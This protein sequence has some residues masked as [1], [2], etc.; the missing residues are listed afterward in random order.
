MNDTHKKGKIVLWFCNILLIMVAVVASMVY[1]SHIRTTQKKVKKTDFITTV[2][3]MKQLSQNY[4]DGEK[5]YLNN[6]A[7]YITKHDMTLSESLD[8]LRQINTNKDRFA[9]IVDMDTFQ[10][11]SSYYPSGK[12]EISTY[13]YYKQKKHLTEYE[14]SFVTMMQKMFEG[15]EA[16]FSV[17]GKITIPETLES[18]VGLGAKVSIKTSYGKKDYLLVR[19]VPT[20]AL[21]RN[22]VFPV[23]YSSAEVGII[24]RAGD[25]VIQSE[26]MKS[27]S[28]LEYIRAYNFSN[29]YNKIRELQTQ[30]K[31]TDYGT[32]TY[33]NF[34]GKDCLW[35]YSSFGK[36]SDLNILGCVNLEQLQTSDNAW[37]IV[38]LICVTLVI[39]S[40]IDGSYFYFM[41]RKL[42]ETARLANQASEAKTQFLS[43]MSHDIRTPMNGVLGMMSIA[44]KNINN[45]EYVMECLDKSMNAGKQLL[46]LINDVLDISKI[47]SGKLILSKEK[48]NLNEMI[49]GLVDMLSTQMQEKNLAFSCDLDGLAHPDVCADKMRLNQVF[50]N[51]L[52]NAVKYTNDG[53]SIWLTLKEEAFSEEEETTSIVF[54]VKDTGIGM[55]EEFQ[56]NMYTSFSRA[57]STQVNETQGTGLGL[58][59]VKQM[60]NLM[61]GSI[62]CTSQV[63]V[64]STFEVRLTLPILK[65]IEDV[66]LSNANEK[67]EV[68]DL[69]LLIAEDNELN[70]EIIEIM[71]SEYGVK[72]DRVKNGLLCLKRIQKVEAGTYDAILMDIQMPIMNGM[73][74][75]KNIRALDDDRKNKIPIIA[76]TADAFAEDVQAC[77][78]CGMNGHIAKPIDSSKL[79]EYL[80]KIKKNNF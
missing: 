79:L 29:D 59:I 28:F 39:L 31:Y 53:G 72:V 23:E 40:L 36:D 37:F 67:V 55:T 47:E 66:N 75:T 77:F 35:Y 57:V 12:E 13:L 5:G 43:A 48:I 10:A 2:E 73:E 24:T 45:P 60:L 69:H 74:A 71:L 32:L 9:H 52:S 27:I 78:Q 61:G 26:S 70:W 19:M 25:Y 49:N 21:R 34:R 51:I 8:F 17:M 41:N 64:G 7:S 1:S 16:Q 22:W 44:Q 42:R 62:D 33:K 65:E 50:V 20:N 14:Q 63:G 68:G 3:S 15:K 46:T 18:A 38:Y 30:L 54:L 4:L 6:W 76:M 58:S 56:K 11:Y 80:K